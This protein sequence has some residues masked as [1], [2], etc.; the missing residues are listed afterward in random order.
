MKP[1]IQIR[2]KLR[3]I[4]RI[5]LRIYCNTL[6]LKYMYKFEFK[7]EDTYIYLSKTTQSHSSKFMT[8]ANNIQWFNIFDRCAQTMIIVSGVHFLSPERCL[9]IHDIL[10]CS[11][12]DCFCVIFKKDS[13]AI[14]LLFCYCPFSYA[15][16]INPLIK[17][18]RGWW[19]PALIPKKNNVK[20][21]PN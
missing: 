21:C 11:P 2:N 20:S 17:L 4:E 16:I 18:K 5:S 6:I 8:D 13:N 15:H 19:N 3:K 9:Y 10:K 14:S 12:L 1:F 7:K